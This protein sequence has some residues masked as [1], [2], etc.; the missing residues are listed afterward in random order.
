VSPVH[1]TAPP[2]TVLEGFS[3]ELTVATGSGAL[4]ILEL[5]GASGSRLPISEFL[6]G[7]RIAPGES[8]N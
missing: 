8:L 6:R 2:G 4:C 7:H 3:D 1:V 5:Q